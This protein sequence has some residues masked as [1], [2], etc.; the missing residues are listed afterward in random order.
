M[1]VL[2][3]LLSLRR[4]KR[5]HYLQC[6]TCNHPNL[7]LFFFLCFLAIL[8]VEDGQIGCAGALLAHIKRKE[9]E[10]DTTID[11]SS[12]EMFHLKDAMHLTVDTLK[13]FVFLTL[14]NV[15]VPM[16]CQKRIAHLAGGERG[17]LSASKASII[18]GIA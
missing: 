7:Y 2:S 3:L 9:A 17:P 10:L 6:W 4:R 13:Y 1:V 8:L 14:Y 16:L 11:V 12:I 15:K 5:L 18:D